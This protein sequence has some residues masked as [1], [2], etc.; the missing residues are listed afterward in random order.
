MSTRINS[1][2]IRCFIIR[3][4]KASNVLLH[5]TENFIGKVFSLQDRLWPFCLLAAGN[6]GCKVQSR[7]YQH[8]LA[9]NLWRKEVMTPQ[10]TQLIRSPNSIRA[11]CW[12][13]KHTKM[14]KD[15]V[16]LCWSMLC[17]NTANSDTETRLGR[18]PVQISAIWREQLC[19]RFPCTR[20]RTAPI[21]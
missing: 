17:R 10:P 2:Q 9:F 12:K 8:W 13:A 1:A 19:T 7:F 15:A 21:T 20:R 18:E 14:T 4:R 16:E 5:Q 11:C 6:Y 3:A